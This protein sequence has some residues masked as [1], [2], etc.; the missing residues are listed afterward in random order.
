MAGGMV[1]PYTNSSSPSSTNIHFCSRVMP[2]WGQ[3]QCLTLIVVD[4]VG[5]AVKVIGIAIGEEPEHY[6]PDPESEDKDPA[7]VTLGRESASRGP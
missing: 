3:C 4:V 2:S 6:G 5:N 7:A 1:S